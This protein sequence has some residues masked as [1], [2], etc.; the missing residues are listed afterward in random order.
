MANSQAW[1]PIVSKKKAA[2]NVSLAYRILTEAH[3]IEDLIEAERLLE[4]ALV[5][6]RTLLGIPLE[7]QRGYRPP[8]EAPAP[9][10]NN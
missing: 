1:T 4:A 7:H 2:S 6:V 5:E 9:A 8:A 10:R 3:E